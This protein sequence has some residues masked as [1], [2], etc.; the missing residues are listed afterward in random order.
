[1][2]LGRQLCQARKQ[3]GMSQEEVASSLHVSRQ[4]I[5]K[6]ET[7]E[8]VPDVVFAK[9]LAALYH[10]SLDQLLEYDLETEKVKAM[11]DQMSEQTSR[12]INWNKV[13]SSKYPIL[14]AYKQQVNTQPYID[15]LSAMLFQLQR[16]YG[17]N[18]Q[19]AFLVL[20]DIL[21]HIWNQR[22]Q[23]KEL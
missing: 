13:W 20:K 2:K 12:K 18:D 21:A 11:V 3:S 19:D 16:D 7:D 1:M 23:K 10:L 14:D 4:T 22:A 8:T 5:S 15:N 17:Y 6:W 9:K